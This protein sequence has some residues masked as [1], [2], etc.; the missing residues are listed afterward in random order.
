MLES[1]LTEDPLIEQAVVI[2]D[3]RSYLTALLVPHAG[4][5]QAEITRCGI[6]V[7][8]KEAALVNEEVLA[9]YAACIAQRLRGLSQHEQVRK[10]TLVSRGFSIESGEL[11]P[12]LSLRRKIIEKNFAAEIAAMYGV[13]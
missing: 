6:A 2:G 7:A 11:T 10:F 13:S 3:D 9:L 4:N 5:L 8:S 1:L 12:K